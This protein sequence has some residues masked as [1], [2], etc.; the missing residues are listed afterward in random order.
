MFSSI[1]VLAMGMMLG[2][3]TL[4]SG[5]GSTCSAPLGGGTAAAGDPFWMQT[6]RH[7]GLSAF[8][9]NPT[10]YQVFR[11]VKDF[12]ARGDGTTDDTAA[13]KFVR[14][15]STLLLLTLL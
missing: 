13:I 12:G 9:A 5:L 14:S 2:S 11:N 1:L 10:S 8:N 7:Q 3:L 6:I 15:S 4:V